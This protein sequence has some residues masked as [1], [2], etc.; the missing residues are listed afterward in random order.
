MAAEDDGEGWIGP[1]NVTT[2]GKMGVTGGH[3]GVRARTSKR[4]ADVRVG[5]V[6]TDYAMQNVLLQ[7]GLSLL[8]VDGRAIDRVKQ[9]VLK[10][11]A[12]FKITTDMSKMFCPM[13]G[14][15]TLARLG[16]TLDAKGNPHYHYKRNR[17]VRTT[18]SKHSLPAARG[19]RD[20][21]LLLREDQLLTG[22]WRQRAHKKTAASS[23]FDPYDEARGGKRTGVDVVV[24]YGRRNPN[25]MRGRERRGQKKNKRPGR[26]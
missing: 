24:G 2:G 13:C 4:T 10:C 3:W 5:C 23:M 25:A 22:A 26:K 1:E 9:W 17:V 7:M 19:G 6:T 16:V 11:D 20:G 18:G 8:T 12:C 14:N 15:A 21:D